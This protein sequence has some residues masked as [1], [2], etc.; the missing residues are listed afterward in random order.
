M[1][2]IH[3]NHRHQH[4]FV[5]TTTPTT[6]APVVPTTTAPAITTPSESTTTTASISSVPCSSCT[7]TTSLGCQGSDCVA[8]STVSLETSYTSSSLSP[9]ST[10]SVSIYEGAGNGKAVSAATSGF[11]FGLFAWVLL[12]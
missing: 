10:Y 11:L 8:V 9:T 7:R 3:I 12:I 4:V 6:P 2:L 1:Y 5:P